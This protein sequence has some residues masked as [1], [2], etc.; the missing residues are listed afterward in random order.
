MCVAYLAGVAV[1]VVTQLHTTDTQTQTQRRRHTR[2]SAEIGQTRGPEDSLQGSPYL[3]H[4]YIYIYI[5]FISKSY[6]YS[7]YI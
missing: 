3:S 1:Q 6:M 2:G 4:I 7:I 5:Q